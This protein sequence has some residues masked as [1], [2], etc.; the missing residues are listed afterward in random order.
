MAVN[1]RQAIREAVAEMLRRGETSAAGRVFEMRYDAW[2][3]GE[4]PAIGVYTLEETV[5]QSTRAPRGEAPNLQLLV[6]A[7]VAL[8]ANA[9]AAV[10]E[11]E[12]EIRNV[13]GADATKLGGTVLSAPR[14]RGTTIAVAEEASPAVAEA[15]ITYDV[16]YFTPAP[17]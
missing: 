3:P 7:V 16:T 6:V 17:A 15:R 4:L 10:E 1:Q 9:V 11:L 2:R 12:L 5:E 8:D 14:R 13:I